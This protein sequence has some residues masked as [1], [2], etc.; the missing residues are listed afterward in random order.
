MI[1][2]EASITIV[3]LAILIDERSINATVRVAG[4]YISNPGLQPYV[5]QILVHPQENYGEI[6]QL[7]RT[8]GIIIPLRNFRVVFEFFSFLL[9]WISRYLSPNRDYFVDVTYRLFEKKK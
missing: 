4:E 2:R 9:F 3:H 8:H 1:N 5:R 6:C 7:P